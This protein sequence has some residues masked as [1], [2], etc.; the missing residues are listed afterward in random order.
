MLWVVG[1]VG[2]GSQAHSGRA[3]AE[4]RNGEAL[5]YRVGGYSLHELPAGAEGE[6]GD[7]GL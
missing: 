7:W 2:R 1:A 4:G 6:T 5:G 3:R